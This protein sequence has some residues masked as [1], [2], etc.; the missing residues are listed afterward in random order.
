MKRTISLIIAIAVMVS[1]F[2][3]P[4]SAAEYVFDMSTLSG[5]ARFTAAEAVTEW[6]ITSD[7]VGLHYVTG[8]AGVTNGNVVDIPLDLSGC[9]TMVITY[10]NGV[11]AG[12]ESSDIMLKSADYATTY[13]TFDLKGT[14]NWGTTAEASIDVSSITA[15]TTTYHLQI[16]ENATNGAWVT[17]IKLVGDNVSG[18]GSTTPPVS[19]TTVTTVDAIAAGTSVLGADIAGGKSIS[20][21]TYVIDL[22]GY[23]WTGQLFVS[24][25]ADVTIM[26]SST[27]KTGVF[28]ATN[29]GDGIDVSGGKIT[30][31]GVKVIGGFGSGDA[32]FVSGG[33]VVSNNSILCAGKAAIDV[34]SPS[35]SV[36]VNG[37]TFATFPATDS[38]PADERNCAIEFRANATVT[39]NGDID[40]TVNRLIARDGHTNTF[41]AS[42][43]T[44]ENVTVSYTADA[45]FTSNTSYRYTDMTYT[46]TVPAGDPAFVGAS[47]TLTSGIALNFIAE[48]V[49]ADDY[50]VVKGNQISGVAGTGEYAGM[51]IFSVADFGPQAI[52]D[53]ITAEL[54]AD[55]AKVE[56]LTY[57]VK[58]YCYDVID[59]TNSSAEL[60]KLAKAV[61]NYA[62]ASQVFKNYKVSTPANAGLTEAEKDIATNYIPWRGAA[63]VARERG[64]KA[65]YVWRTANVYFGDTHKLIITFTTS[66]TN[67][68]TATPSYV[69]YTNEDGVTPNIRH[70]ITD[71]GNNIYQIVFD[72]ILPTEFQ[73]DYL[74]SVYDEQGNKLANFLNYSIRGY[75]SMNDN[76]NRDFE[77][78]SVG[79]VEPVG[80][81]NDLVKALWL[82]G[83]AATNYVNSL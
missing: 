26:D 38:T 78:D 30:L 46:Y 18:G 60:V 61:L 15:T 4:A 5:V 44:G 57:S 28:D 23:K 70:E 20:S 54:Y 19:G 8:E 77:Y 47:V 27:G 67:E 48:G 52:G 72:D 21:G 56:E 29:M 80:T 11:A 63:T 6:G 39:L 33:T 50:I 62:T 37:G 10:R 71:L 16:Q 69:L 7:V 12:S 65:Q 53:D 83:E 9:D 51:Y 34:T 58:Q 2:V 24:G 25:T 74:L 14:G 13:G 64:F 76:E 82:Y 49:D 55:G 22:A 73:T 66:T 35:A 59:D 17:G 42:V 79:L 68:V 43:T 3:L 31:D 40:F 1:M 41:A 45:T 36:T 32:L 81:I 75:V